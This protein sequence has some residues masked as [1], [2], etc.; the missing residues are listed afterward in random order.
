MF[1]LAGVASAESFQ[2]KCQAHLRIPVT[3]TITER[4]KMERAKAEDG[5]G[6]KAKFSTWKNDETTETAVAVEYDLVGQTGISRRKDEKTG[7]SMV[8]WELLEWPNYHHQVV[9]AFRKSERFTEGSSV[10]IREIRRGEDRRD[11]TDCVL[12]KVRK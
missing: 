6:Y 10:Q 9:I 3:V 5:Y 2:Y 12:E 11:Y 1:C 8:Q 7:E 4:S